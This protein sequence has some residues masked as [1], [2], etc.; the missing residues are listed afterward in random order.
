MKKSLQPV[1]YATIFQAKFEPKISYFQ[2]VFGTA[3]RLEDYPHWH[4]DTVTA[5]MRDFAHRRSAT[6]NFGWIGYRQDKNDIAQERASIHQLLEVGTS[7]LNVKKFSR[8]GFRRKY[9]AELDLEYKDLVGLVQAKLL[10]PDI[11][12]VKSSSAQLE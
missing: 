5:S 6:F 9:L 4:T 11:G 10:S 2:S 7:G 1:A 12:L 3:A 8:V